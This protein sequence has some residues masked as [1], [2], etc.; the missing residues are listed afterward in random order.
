M[1][2]LQFVYMRC[3]IPEL[4]PALRDSCSQ[5]IMVKSPEHTLAMVRKEA[6]RRNVAAT[7][8]LISRDEY[9]AFRKARKDEI[10][11]RMVTR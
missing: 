5:V 6:A 11:A 9:L 4:I 7:Y 2:T 8:E 3:T 10:A 1:S